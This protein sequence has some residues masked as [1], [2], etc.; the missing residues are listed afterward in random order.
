MDYI[1]WGRKESGTTEQLNTNT[2]TYHKTLNFFH[3]DEKYWFIG[4]KC[5][6]DYKF[7]KGL[8]LLLCLI[9]QTTMPSK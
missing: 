5:V 9:I 4:L 1:P 8:S 2:C 7:N 6:H 3:H